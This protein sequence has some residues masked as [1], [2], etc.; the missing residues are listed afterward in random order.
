MRL[1]GSPLGDPAK[2]CDVHRQASSN[3]CLP[4][5]DKPIIFDAFGQ[6]ANTGRP[7]TCAPEPHKKLRTT[8]TRAHTPHRVTGRSRYNQ[9]LSKHFENCLP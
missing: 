2:N 5:F 4:K 3:F 9:D 1:A 7:E 6:F 8:S